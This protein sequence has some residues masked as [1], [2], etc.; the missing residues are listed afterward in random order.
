ME[1]PEGDRMTAASK[2]RSLQKSPSR[3][4]L[5]C[6]T[7]FPWREAAVVREEMGKSGFAGKPWLRIQDKEKPA[8]AGTWRC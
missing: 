1:E 6:R 7:R 5:V 8:G 3:G 4:K 2:L